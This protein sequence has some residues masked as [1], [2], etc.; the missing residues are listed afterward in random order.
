M[1]TSIGTIGVS[2]DR[3]RSFFGMVFSSPGQLLGT[4]SRGEAHSFFTGGETSRRSGSLSSQQV[5]VS[6]LLGVRCG[7]M[8]YTTPP[9]EAALA[10][11]FPKYAMNRST[12]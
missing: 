4:M 2:D 8:T 12:P 6:G 1:L 9:K 11:E 5:G 10:K 7:E 3:C